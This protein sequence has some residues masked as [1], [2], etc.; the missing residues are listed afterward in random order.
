MEKND[1]EREEMREN[2][3]RKRPSKTAGSQTDDDN[4][5]CSC[6]NMAA[7]IEAINQRL[8]L[9]LS[10]FQEIDDLKENLKDLQKEN[11]DLKESLSYAHKDF[12][13][14]K[15]ISKFHEGAIEA[16]QIGVNGLQKDIKMERERAIRLESHSRRNNLNF[17]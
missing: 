5:S 11:I 16:Q 15:E 9:A 12:A 13:E 3:G 2:Q 17:F 6:L 4:P 10:K 8:D 14:L 7:T 1:V